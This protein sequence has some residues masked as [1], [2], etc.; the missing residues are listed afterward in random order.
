M[1]GLIDN[2]R[3]L[4]RY[5][6]GFNEQLYN[7]CE[8][9]DDAAR[10]APRG[11]FFGSIHGT[12]NHILW[13]DRVWLGRLAAQPGT[14][15]GWPATLLALPDGARHETL[16]Y[17]NWAELRTHRRELDIA[18]EAWLAR[19]PD[20]GVQ[21]PMRYHNTLGVRREHPVWQALTHLFNHQTH[22]RGQI[23]TLLAQAGVDVGVT[24]LIA[25]L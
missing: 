20:D 17:A 1:A 14:D 13:G 10:T 18:L 9:L 25:W 22:H 21:R 4:A 12:L 7:A 2:Y 5:N 19:L 3:W 6:T 23:T 16:L 11:A 8:R 24:D 15:T